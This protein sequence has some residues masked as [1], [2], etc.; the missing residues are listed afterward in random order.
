MAA[1]LAATMK[2]SF[3]RKRDN[4][5]EAL[6]EAQRQCGCNTKTLS[7]VYK[8]ITPFLHQPAVE[9]SKKNGQTTDGNRPIVLELHGCCKCN[10]FV[11]PPTSRRLRCPKCNHPRFN[12]KKK[13]N[14]VFW[15]LP[16]KYQIANLLKNEQYRELLMWETRRGSKTNSGMMSDV[17][18]TPRWRQVAGEATK[19]LSRIVYQICVDAFPWQSRKHGVCNHSFKIPTVIHS[20][21]QP[22]FIQNPQPSFIQI[23]PT[24][25]PI[26]MFARRDL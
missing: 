21:S 17:Y 11:F 8:Q 14:E 2:K 15:Y 9:T 18:D 7:T 26:I 20:K 4:L 23:N 16:L 10:D 12:S 5:W 19:T 25:I 3:K 1:T 6:R 22:S 24:V 13:A